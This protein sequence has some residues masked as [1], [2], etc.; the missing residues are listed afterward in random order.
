MLALYMLLWTQCPQRAVCVVI[1]GFV[2]DV[3]TVA[4][5]EPPIYD[6]RPFPQYA[7]AF[8]LGWWA[9]RESGG[10]ADVVSPDG[11]DCG[12]MGMRITTLAKL[13]H[14]CDD[15]RKDRKLGLRLGLQWIRLLKSLCPPG[16]DSTECALRAYA[17]GSFTKGYSL[18]TKRCAPIGG[19]KDQ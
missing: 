12:A 8:L 18:V 10:V 16:P 5:E 3:W 6:T 4:A 19:C 2:S 7:T 14:T 9:L 11:L 1:P 17:T 15:V 13:G